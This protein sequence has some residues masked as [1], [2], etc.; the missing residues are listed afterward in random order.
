MLGKKDNLICY[1]KDMAIFYDK[2]GKLVFGNRSY[3]YYGAKNIRSAKIR[4]TKY[5]N[6]LNKKEK[7]SLKYIMLKPVN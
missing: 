7:D 6:K 4:I 1:Y 3:R 2:N 5:I